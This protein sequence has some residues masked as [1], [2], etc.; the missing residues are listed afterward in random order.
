[1]LQG[2]IES[3]PASPTHLQGGYKIIIIT[4][5]SINLTQLTDL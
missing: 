2:Y 5:K 3:N 4:I 1:M